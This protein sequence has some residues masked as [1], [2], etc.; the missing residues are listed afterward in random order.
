MQYIKRWV[1]P[2]KQEFYQQRNNR[3]QRQVA[4]LHAAG[5]RPV[6]EAILA[7]AAGQSID[8]VLADFARVPVIIYHAIGANELPVD[9]RLQ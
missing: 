4:H 7:V 9:R 3:R 6:L 5:P 1:R 2:S 8:A